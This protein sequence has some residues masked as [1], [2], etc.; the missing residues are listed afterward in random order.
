MTSSRVIRLLR[1]LPPTGYEISKNENMTLEIVFNELFKNI[2]FDFR[3]EIFVTSG[4]TFQV[5]TSG[6]LKIG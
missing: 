2:V 4:P 5:I 3:F 1:P 6:K